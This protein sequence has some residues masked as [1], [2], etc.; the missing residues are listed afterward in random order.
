MLCK[1]H[2]CSS[3]MSITTTKPLLMSVSLYLVLGANKLAILNGPTNENKY[4]QNPIELKV[5]P[6]LGKCFE[7]SPNDLQGGAL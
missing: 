7:H 4:V 3:V 5:S 6:S 1:Y 2:I